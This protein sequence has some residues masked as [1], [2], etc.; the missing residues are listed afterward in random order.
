MITA[1]AGRRP[2]T[3]PLVLGAVAVVL[4]GCPLLPEAVPPWIRF[5]PVYAVVPLGVCAIVFGVSDLFGMRGDG[6]ADRRR[7]RAGVV[8]GTVAILV[9]LGSVLWAISVLGP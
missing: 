7:A 2:G 5:A 3:V 1:S 6:A 4:L 8:L 9:P